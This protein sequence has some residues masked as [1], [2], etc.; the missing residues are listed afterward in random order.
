[1][2]IDYRSLAKALNATDK[3]ITPYITPWII[4]HGDDPLSEE[5]A[6]KIKKLL[7]T[8]PRV[9]SGSFSASSAGDCHRA[10]VFGFLGKQQGVVDAQLAN[11][12]R[13]GKW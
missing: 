10:Q 6:E 1:M 7:V 5:T 8:P 9:R 12:F 3:I 4:K 13:D 11:I 2:G